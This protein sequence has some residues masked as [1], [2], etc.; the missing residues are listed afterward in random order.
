MTNS[1]QFNSEPKEWFGE[2]FDSPYYHILYQHRDHEEAEAFI[3][4]LYDYFSFTPEDE[5][6]DLACGK[7]RHSIYLNKKGLKVTGVDLSPQN[8]EA[9][10]KQ[11]NER[12]HF[13]VHDMR[14]VFREEDFDYVLNLFTSFGYFETEKE[15]Q[16]AI[17]AAAAALRPGGQFLI[18]FLNPYVVVHNMRP[19]E[20]KVLDGIE[21]H[22]S[23]QLDKDNYIVKDIRFK[24]KGKTY[25][26][27]ERVKAIRRMEFL[28]YFRHAGLLVEDCFGDYK[29]NAYEAGESDRMIFVCRKPK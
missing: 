3:D 6:M 11:A 16:Q 8:I 2:W 15:N 29:L 7:G 9:A 19:E 1:P 23:K 4:H 25:H 22:L 20:V 13:H 26:F 17:D 14:E 12:L 5:V 27:Q 18:D 10:N 21:F 24:D 28:E